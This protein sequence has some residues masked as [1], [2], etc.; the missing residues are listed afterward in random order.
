MAFGVELFT[1]A[2]FPIRLINIYL[3]DYAN[4][5]RS[6]IIYLLSDQSSAMR[7]SSLVTI[8]LGFLISLSLPSAQPPVCSNKGT[9]S[10]NSTYDKNL[11]LLLSSPFQHHS[12]WWLLQCH[13]WPR[14]QQ[15][16]YIALCR[17]DLDTTK[18]YN[19]VDK[20]SQDITKQCP[21][22][23]EAI[24]WGAA[25]ILRYSNQKHFWHHGGCA[26]SVYA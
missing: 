26:F 6:P 13:C 19:C 11:N 21:N 3:C 1:A 5:C 15:S 8:A 7:Y 20:S 18:C 12:Q 25:C 17:G 24:I 23:K 14:P 9:F 16:L 22:Q 2:A 10:T 4:V